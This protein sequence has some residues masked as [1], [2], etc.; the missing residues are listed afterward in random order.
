M[1]LDRGETYEGKEADD[2]NEAERLEREKEIMLEN[3]FTAFSMVKNGR[4]E[5]LEVSGFSILF[6]VRENSI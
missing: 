2:E 4:L 1:A 6:I 5:E 3:T